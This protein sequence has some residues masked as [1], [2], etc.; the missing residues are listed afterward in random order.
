[1]ELGVSAPPYYIWPHGEIKLPS[2]ANFLI[3]SCLVGGARKPHKVVSMTVSPGQ[4]SVWESDK[5]VPGSG[6]CITGKQVSA[7]AAPGSRGSAH[8]PSTG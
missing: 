8:T 5:C 2:R 1:M 4:A 3:P 6:G 7:G